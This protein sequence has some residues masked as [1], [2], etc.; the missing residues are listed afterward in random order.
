MSLYICYKSEWIIRNSIAINSSNVIQLNVLTKPDL[1]CI[2]VYLV[3]MRT[4]WE[5]HGLIIL[6]EHFLQIYCM[7]LN[8]SISYSLW[9]IY[10]L[11]TT[12]SGAFTI[13]VHT[14]TGLLFQTIR[15]VTTLKTGKP[16]KYIVYPRNFL[17]ELTFVPSYFNYNRRS[18]CTHY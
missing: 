16:L 12:L 1:V 11:F 13:S 15:N 14:F 17:I 18:F 9:N 7:N 3:F 10:I 6:R 2:L 4:H 5:N 8:S